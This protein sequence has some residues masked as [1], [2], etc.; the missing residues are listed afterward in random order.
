MVKS[1][2]YTILNV[3]EGTPPIYHYDFFR[4]EDAADFV[5]L[6]LD[7]YWEKGISIVEWPKSFCYSLPGRKI[8]VIIAITGERERTIEVKGA[9]GDQ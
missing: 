1:P 9:D 2:T 3:Y 7:D 8:D 5:S 6:G 4:V